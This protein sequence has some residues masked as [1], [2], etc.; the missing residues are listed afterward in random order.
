MQDADLRLGLGLLACIGS[1]AYLQEHRS[2][3]AAMMKQKS[4][5]GKKNI[6]PTPE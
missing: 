1:S 3:Q 6:S 2:W 5:K 4:N